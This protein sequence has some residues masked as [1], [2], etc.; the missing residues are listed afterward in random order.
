MNLEAVIYEVKDSI[1]R[2]TMNRPEKRNALNHAL[3]DDLIA[4]FDEAENDREVR[5][6]ILC[7]A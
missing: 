5:V 1:A 6:V 7:G 3:W 2:I 4:A